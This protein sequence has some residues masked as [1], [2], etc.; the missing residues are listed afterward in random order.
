MRRILLGMLMV[1]AAV[2]A[3]AQTDVIVMRKPMNDVVFK[4]GEGAY[5]PKPGRW[6]VGDPVVTPGCSATQPTT[7]PVSCVDDK[8]KPI[9]AARCTGPKP[10]GTGTTS[11]Y[12]TCTYSPRV[13]DWTNWSSTCSDTA[14]R[15]R[16][17][18]CFRSD[19]SNLD[20]SKCEGTPPP[21]DETASILTGCSYQSN[22][23]PQGACVPTGV[24]DGGTRTAKLTSCVR[25][26]GK[27]V[28]AENA[29]MAT[30]FC[31]LE[32]K[33]SCVI[34][35]VG[36]WVVGTPVVT[37][38]CSATQ[39]T[40]AS[41]TCA[42]PDGKTIDAQYCSASKPSGSG[43]AANYDACTY[44]AEASAWGSWSSTCSTT[45]S[46]S[47]TISCRRSDN[48]L[49]TDLT[50]CPQPLPDT[51]E[52]SGVF[53]GCSYTGTY[54]TPGACVADSD[55]V[56][57]G[58]QT[59]ALTSCLRSDGTVLTGT[60]A[61]SFCTPTRAT[62][63]TLTTTAKYSTTYSTCSAGLQYAPIT[64]CRRSDGKVVANSLCGADKQ[65]TSQ[66][67]TSAPTGACETLGSSRWTGKFINGNTSYRTHSMTVSSMS[68]V[69]AAC[70]TMYKQYGIGSCFASTGTG[71][72]GVSYYEQYAWIT[73][74]NRPDLMAANCGQ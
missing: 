58:R 12:S 15:F 4:S 45:A 28:T 73:F 38:G 7:A 18:W 27:Y 74:S 29:G 57:T 50:L 41:V 37:P 9:E 70:E 1:S 59:A 56:L 51:T 11:N 26:D 69:Q 60:E 55:T 39:P 53:T 30:P 8:G 47:R 17:T 3:A 68:A 23:G 34:P 66:T 13:G 46:H 25:S 22:Y 64:E 33:T 61:A 36:H 6:V 62:S 63:C 20:I 48:T 67:C 35:P 16:A 40:Q 10:T 32:Q 31:E 49:V 65:T 54:G 24:G 52:K 21:G 19:G 5:T 42:G 14:K 72:I 2:P 71:P 43:T 44:K